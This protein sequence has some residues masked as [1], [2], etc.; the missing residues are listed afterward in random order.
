MKK[1]SLPMKSKTNINDYSNINIDGVQVLEVA[2]IAFD[3]PP[4]SK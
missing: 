3:V 4:T 1:T 2:G